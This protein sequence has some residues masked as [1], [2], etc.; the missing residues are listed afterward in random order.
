MRVRWATV[1]DVK[2]IAR[3]WHHAWHG[4]HS[5]FVSPDALQLCTL[6]SFE[7]R[8][9]SSLFEQDTRASCPALSRRPTMLVAEEEG[10]TSFEEDNGLAGFA[11]ISGGATLEHLYVDTNFQGH[12]IGSRL[13]HAAENVMLDER[14]NSVAHLVVAMR[15]LRAIKFY[16]RHAWYSADRL[17]A[18]STWEPVHLEEAHASL[19]Q[20]ERD[21]TSMR[22]TQFRKHLGYEGN[23]NDG[24]IGSTM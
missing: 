15:N 7:A 14:H 4:A 11:V 23:P 3:L 5:K 19:T 9:Q 13:L 12:G 1:A 2:S 6:R 18:V 21:A 17:P 20:A 8:A 10:V 24:E 22:C 16:K